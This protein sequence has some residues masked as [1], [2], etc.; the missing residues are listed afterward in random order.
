MLPKRHLECLKYTYENGCPWDGWIC[1]AA[2]EG[3]LECLRYAHEN[4]C[5]WDK[6]LSNA[7][8]SHLECLQSYENGCRWDKHTCSYVS[9][10]LESFEIRARKRIS[11][12]RRTCEF[13]L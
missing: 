9:V 2:L 6:N 10:H 5:P 8:K 12:D 4:G 1:D 7:A 13:T 3:R 11:P